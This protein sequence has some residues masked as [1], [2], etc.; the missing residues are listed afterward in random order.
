MQEEKKAS[1]EELGL[2][3]ELVEATE[4]LGFTHPTAIQVESIPV[5]LKG[6]DVIGL[7]QTGS[8]KVCKNAEC[9]QDDPIFIFFCYLDG[10]LF[11]AN[12][13]RTLEGSVLCLRL[14]FGSHSGI[15]CSNW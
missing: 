4:K 5:A 11:A 6:R 3:P 14:H 7:A 1:F 9:V 13:T 12:I 10:C 8:G 2:I 15:G